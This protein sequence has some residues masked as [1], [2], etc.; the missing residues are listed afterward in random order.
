MDEKM[1]KH[2]DLV[3]KSS[4]I[5]WWS[6]I[7]HLDIPMPKTNIVGLTNND[8]RSLYGLIEN[9][10][11]PDALKKELL[12][13]ANDIG[14]PLFMRSDQGSGKHQWNDTC[15]VK[16]ETNLINQLGKLID[17]HGSLF[18][19]M[20]FGAIVF[21]S[22]IEMDSKFCAFEGLPIAR[23]RR[24]FIKDGKI[25]D[26]TPYWP[27]DAIRFYNSTKEYEDAPWKEMLSELNKEAPEEIDLL[28]G[29]ALEVAKHFK[30]YWSVDFCK[31]KNGDWYL[32]DMARG[33]VSWNP[34]ND[35]KEKE[36][37]SK[38]LEEINIWN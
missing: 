38:F 5:N 16:D 33:E 10:K 6:V 35:E 23:E 37:T 28:S 21:R 20:P 26:H 15:F 4:M 11:L 27:E 34:K 2:Y 29:Y 14:Y 24:Y 18:P 30:E 31:A 25:D 3:I 17:W 7:K 9:E 19:P 1:E 32:L 36:K 13:A 8:R 12:D 22:Y